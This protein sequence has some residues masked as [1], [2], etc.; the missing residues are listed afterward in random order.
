[1]S[2]ESS[3]APKRFYTLAEAAPAD[4][5]FAILLDGRAVLTPRRER[6][7]LPVLPLAALIANEWAEQGDTIRLAAMRATRLAYT[8]ADRVAGARK[9]TVAEVVRFAGSDLL[10][11]FAEAPQ[12]LV[13]RQ[14]AQWRPLLDW[15]D[16]ALGVRLNP[17]AGIIHAAQP[18]ESLAR[19]ETL[20]AETDAF[21][22]AALTFAA[23]LY[24]S[25]VLAL[26]V[27]KGELS[28][29]QAYEISRLDEAFQQ[30]QWG[31]DDEAAARTAHGRLDAVMLQA[32]FAALR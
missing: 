20:C 13:Q 2:D 29:E 19:I 10:C 3:L 22:L 9:E 6:L 24:G 31:V 12:A 32:W 25:A 16:R 1:M 21:T 18:A 23:A 8:A 30:E 15:A 7:I 28:G 14:A 26:A 27:M 4:G 5:G 11:Y 17:V